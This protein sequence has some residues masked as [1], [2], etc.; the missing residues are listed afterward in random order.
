M[1][2]P[3]EKPIIPWKLMEG[4]NAKNGTNRKGRNKPT[5][6]EPTFPSDPGTLMENKDK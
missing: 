6:P 1:K 2:F 3:K 5:F 4:N